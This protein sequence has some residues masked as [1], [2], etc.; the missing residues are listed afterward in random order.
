M[1]QTLYGLVR[2]KGIANFF[3]KKLQF[4]VTDTESLLWCLCNHI[5]TAVRAAFSDWLE[6][7]YA[8][9]GVLWLWSTSPEGGT[10][11]PPALLVALL[12]ESSVQG[13]N[14]VAPS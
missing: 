7:L 3:V 1:L 8:L 13:C 14:S 12:V 6:F 11:A 5:M 2:G 10:I 4:Q 9:V